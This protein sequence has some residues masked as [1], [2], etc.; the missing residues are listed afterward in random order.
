ME[1][2]LEQ[3]LEDYREL[4]GPQPPQPLSLDGEE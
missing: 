3:L 1:E 2:L 4:A